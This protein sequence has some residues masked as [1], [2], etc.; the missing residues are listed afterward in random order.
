MA[1]ARGRRLCTML[2]GKE[3]GKRKKNIKPKKKEKK[4]YWHV[5]SQQ[6]GQGGPEAVVGLCTNDIYLR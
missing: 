2:G 6:V 3:E 5:V 1:L 4:K